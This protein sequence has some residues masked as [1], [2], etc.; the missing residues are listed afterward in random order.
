[1]SPRP[2]DQ[3]PW[4]WQQKFMPVPVFATGLELRFAVS[5]NVLALDQVR[6]TPEVPSLHQQPGQ[7]TVRLRWQPEHT[8]NEVMLVHLA[9]DG[10]PPQL[11]EHAWIGE[12]PAPAD[13]PQI[14]H[15]VAQQIRAAQA[16]PD[17]SPTAQARRF[18]AELDAETIPHLEHDDD[19]PAVNAER[20]QLVADEVVRIR[21]KLVQYAAH[22]RGR[23][24][25]PVWDDHPEAIHDV[26]EIMDPLLDRYFGADDAFDDAA[27]ERAFVAFA[28]GEL[29]KG[30]PEPHI[31]A[32]DSANFLCFAG[33]ALRVLAVEP[34]SP[35]WRRA[36]VAMARAA[37]IYLAYARQQG[38]RFWG[39]YSAPPAAGVNMQDHELL[40]LRRM[41]TRE[42]GDV[43]R[44]FA[45]VIAENFGPQLREVYPDGPAD[46]D[47]QEGA[48]G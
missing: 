10:A 46:D 28:K 40:E 43:R 14:A 34:A 38:E 35:R 23:A 30:Q 13:D 12:Q 7:R 48:G 17:P 44:Q 5:R 3:G 15:V 25:A 6:V 9:F 41:N 32:P 20:L 47:H 29:A 45:T 18:F 16:D 36:F 1:M 27:L 2:T 11:L 4:E 31:R 24:S 39:S 22:A 37:T 33:F 21:D 42:F 26:R 19:F 8:P